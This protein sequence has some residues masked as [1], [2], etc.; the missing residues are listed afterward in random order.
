LRQ[1]G[2]FILILLFASLAFSIDKAIS[3]VA[4]EYQEAAQKRKAELIRQRF[5]TEKAG[6]EK[7]VKRDLA[8]FVLGCM[9]RIEKG[10]RANEK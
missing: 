8:S 7:V 2:F 6:I 4:P 1:I 10:E 3:G 5:C 9:D